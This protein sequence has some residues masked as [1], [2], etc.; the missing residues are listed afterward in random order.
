MLGKNDD[1]DGPVDDGELL[2]DDDGGIHG[3]L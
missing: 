1:A 3:K 2:V